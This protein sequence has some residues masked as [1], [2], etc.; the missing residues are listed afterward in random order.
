MILKLRTVVIL[1][2]HAGIDVNQPENLKMTNK[3]KT[4]LLSEVH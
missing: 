2:P 3:Q 1:S 4:A